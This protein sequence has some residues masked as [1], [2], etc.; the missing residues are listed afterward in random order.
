MK[1]VLFCIPLKP[2]HRQDFLDFLASTSGN[3]EKLSS[4]KAMLARYDM[5]GVKV[6]TKC[7]SGVDY[8]FVSHEVG[9]QFDEK[10]QAWENSTHEYDQWFNA[11]LM[12]FYD[13]GATDAGATNL[14]EFRV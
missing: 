1:T 4:W 10:I 6:W 2:N 14:L 3:E 11:Q 13:E 8:A 9:E 12:S 5:Y 7:L